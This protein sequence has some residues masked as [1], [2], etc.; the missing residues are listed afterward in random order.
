MR[1]VKTNISLK[2]FLLGKCHETDWTIRFDVTG[3]DRQTVLK[4]VARY[5]QWNYP[6]KQYTITKPANRPGYCDVHFIE[7]GEKHARI[8]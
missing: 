6:G 3:V 7:D 4:R 5:M 1:Y 2:R 8:P